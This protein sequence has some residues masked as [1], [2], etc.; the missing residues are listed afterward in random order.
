MKGC[1]LKELLKSEGVVFGQLAEQLGMSQ[2]SLS[3]VFTRD[4]VKSGTL[5]KIAGAIGKPV[6]YLYGEKAENGAIDNGELFE[7]VK[8]KDEQLLLAMRQTS[9]AQ[10]QMD[11]VLTALQRK[12]VKVAGQEYDIV[13]RPE[14]DM[15]RDIVTER[16]ERVQTLMKIHGLRSRKRMTTSSR[17][18]SDSDMSVP[19]NHDGD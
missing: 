3:A 2:Q 6:G 13:V 10:E 4:D 7:F 9:K 1:E 15:F 17:P 19:A 14:S 18:A 16:N 5:E 11:K 12:T 8:M